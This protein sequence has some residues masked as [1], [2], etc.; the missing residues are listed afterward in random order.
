MRKNKFKDELIDFDA[1]IKKIDKSTSQYKVRNWLLPDKPFRMLISGPS[2]CG[3]TNLLLNMIL[4]ML[5]YDDV[6]LYAKDIHETKYEFLSKLFAENYADGRRKLHVSDNLA[7]VVPYDALDRDRQKI[8][9]F[10]DFNN[11]KDQKAVEDLFKMGRK[12][13]ANVIYLAQAYYKSPKFIRDNCTHYVFFKVHNRQ[14]IGRIHQTHGVD[15][16]KDEF[17]K[18]F[19]SATKGGHDFFYIDTYETELPAKYRM[20]FD[21]F[22]RGWIDDDKKKS[23]KN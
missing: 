3:K 6:Y 18:L 7:D 1:A 17:S 15:L 13:N 19:R 22:Y 16:D 14:D 8:I 9:V 10:D 11:E 12:K 20:G 23:N 2:G 5:Y 21:G 4:K